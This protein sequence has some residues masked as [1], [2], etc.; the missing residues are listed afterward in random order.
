M[1]K[2][3]IVSLALT[4]LMFSMI[5]V[6]PSYSE[7]GKVNE[8]KNENIYA[9]SYVYKIRKKLSDGYLGPFSLSVGCGSYGGTLSQGSTDISVKYSK[10][11]YHMNLGY[12]KDIGDVD[13]N[14]FYFKPEIQFNPVTE[15]TQITSI[16]LDLGIDTYQMKEI[17]FFTEI[18]LN[19]SF[20][21]ETL[22]SG[23]T[24]GSLGFN[25]NMGVYI[26]EY[27]TTGMKI[28]LFRSNGTI[29]GAGKWDY[30]VSNVAWFFGL[31]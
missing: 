21:Q 14:V 5:S 9:G 19:Y 12:R 24:N 23:T 31:R 17:T 28:N 10:A 16:N 20:W 22:F 1:R 18:G 7:E 11:S 3:L 2:N 25:M 27:Y 4:V 13:L 6:S 30:L 26:T 15:G 29:T 8:I